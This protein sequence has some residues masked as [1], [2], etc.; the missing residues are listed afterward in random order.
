M[1]PLNESIIAQITN[2]IR[3]G[4]RCRSPPQRQ[5]GT[6]I[7]SPQSEQLVSRSNCR[8]LARERLDLGTPW[9]LI[10]KIAPTPT[11]LHQFL[12]KSAQLGQAKDGSA[13]RFYKS[14]RVFSS[15]RAKDRTAPSPRSEPHH[16]A[17]DDLSCY[18]GPL[19]SLKAQSSAR[20]VQSRQ[21][22]RSKGGPPSETPS[23]VPH[24]V[25]SPLSK[26]ATVPTYCLSENTSLKKEIPQMS[27]MGSVHKTAMFI[28]FA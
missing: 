8:G 27:A 2:C 10:K 24:L 19:I 15:Q 17:E 3:V 28:S 26:R 5:E 20:P 12:S 13:C 18:K 11:Y 4:H 14:H 9:S 7:L 16:N 22:F 6:N 25:P 1:I 23:F 21:S